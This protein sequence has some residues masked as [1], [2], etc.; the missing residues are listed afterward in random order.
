M[1]RSTLTVCFSR[2]IVI[3]DADPV[4]TQPL[5]QDLACSPVALPL[6]GQLVK[7]P[8]RLGGPKTV[9]A[10]RIDLQRLAGLGD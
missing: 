4:V 7:G 3:R 5:S 8:L 10:Q 9:G 1:M 6:S 2:G